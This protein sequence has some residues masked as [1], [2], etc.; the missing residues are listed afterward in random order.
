MKHRLCLVAIVAGVLSA[1]ETVAASSHAATGGSSYEDLLVLFREW[2]R[3]QQPQMTGGVPDYT[4]GA[5]ERQRRELVGYQ[6]RLAAIDARSWPVAQRIDRELVRAEMNGLEFDHR[7][8]QPWAKDPAFYRVIHPSESDIP[9]VVEGPLLAGST[10]LWRYVPPLS[11]SDLTDLRTRLQAIPKLLQQARTSLSGDARDLWLLGIR[12]K[13]DEGQAL[14]AFAKKAAPHHPDLVG[15]IERA[16]QA[17]D[18]FRGWLEAALPRKKG[19]VGMGIENYD[20]YLKNVHLVP[21]TWRDEVTLFERELARAR[22]Q[23][24]LVRQR[25]RGLPELEPAPSAEEHARRS[26][27]AVTELVRFWGEKDVMTVPPFVDPA[28]RERLSGF[29]PKDRPR[30]FFTQVDLR[31][32][33]LLRCHGIHWFDLARMAKEPHASPIRREPSLYNIWDGRAEGLATGMEEMMLSAGLFAGRPR[34]DELVYVMI[35]NRAARGL[36]GLKVHAGQLT[37]EEALRFA[38]DNTP[39]GWLIADGET[40]W[41]EQQLYLQQPGY[42]T[43]YLTGKAQIE[44]LLGERARELGERFTLKGFFDGFFASGMIPVSLIRWEMTGDETAVARLR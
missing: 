2:R 4:A 29:A 3:F 33:L 31:E 5:M 7:V 21:Y 25:N 16:R 18:A 41:G 12:V 20:W 8:L 38:A 28:L 15:D 1:S 27:N 40:N 43:S 10:F 23:L 35:A 37:V 14:E 26:G 11:E 32:P 42:G 13:K 30:D 36:A 19:R 22:A 44:G 17:I 39:Y 6:K 9:S 34:S 24:A